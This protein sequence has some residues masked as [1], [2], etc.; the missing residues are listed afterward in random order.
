MKNLRR[1]WILTLLIFFGILPNSCGQSGENNTGDLPN[2]LIILADDLGYGDVSCFNENSRIKTSHLDQLAAE[3][4]IFTDAHTS[5]SGTGQLLEVLK[6]EEMKKNTLVFF[7]SDNGCS[8]R[9][10]FELLGELGHAGIRQKND[11]IVF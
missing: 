1:P 8:P 11:G 7:A 2:I 4:M 6:N 3:G 10:N 9:A 5:S